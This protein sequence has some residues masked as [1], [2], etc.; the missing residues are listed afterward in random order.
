M[1]CYTISEA[2]LDLGLRKANLDAL[3]NGM[4]SL[5]YSEITSSISG[6]TVWRNGLTNTTATFDRVNGMVV[7]SY[8]NVE[9]YGTQINQAYTSAVVQMTA[10]KFGWQ[11]QKQG[12]NQFMVQKR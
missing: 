3:K 5:G 8:G 11:V 9:V 10:K 7:K 6:Q 2:K 4:I 12:A 1:P